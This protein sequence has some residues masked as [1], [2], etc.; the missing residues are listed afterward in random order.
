MKHQVATQ[1]SAHYDAH[2]DTKLV[3]AAYDFNL[4]YACKFGT[5][6]GAGGAGGSG[7]GDASTGFEC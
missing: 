5:A 2:A 4:S 1:E 3:K 7:A 6:G